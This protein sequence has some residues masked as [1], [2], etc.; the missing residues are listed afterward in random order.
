MCSSP[1]SSRRLAARYP[2]DDETQ[3]FDALYL[4]ASQSLADKSYTRS[5]KQLRSLNLNLQSTPT[6]RALHTI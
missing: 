4:A 2:D 5:L 1:T 3:I 6:T